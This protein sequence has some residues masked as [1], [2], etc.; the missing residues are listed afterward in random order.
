MRHYPSSNKLDVYEK[1]G[2]DINRENILRKK[3]ISGNL[4][5][6]SIHGHIEIV[7]ENDV[8][9]LKKIDDNEKNRLINIG[10]RLSSASLIPCGGRSR[11]MKEA[12]KTKA[13]LKVLNV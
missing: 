4:K 3:Y 6:P 10:R 11:R 9:N 13:P 5:H 7:N 2:G 8:I 12:I 1:F